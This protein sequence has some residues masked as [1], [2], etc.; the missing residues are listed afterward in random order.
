MVDI[1]NNNKESQRST[2][3]NQQWLLKLDPDGQNSWFSGH[4]Y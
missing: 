2:M 4:W 1:S 3:L